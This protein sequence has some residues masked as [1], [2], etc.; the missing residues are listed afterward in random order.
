M[1]CEA[2]IKAEIARLEYEE[3]SYPNYGK[4]AILYT[5]LNQMNGQPSYEAGYSS[6]PAPALVGSA[7]D[8]DS[9][10]LRVAST[11]DPASTWAIMD[12]LMDTLSVTNPRVYDNVMRRINAL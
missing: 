1:L 10:F 11:K 8:S 9:E 2:E 6:A 12:D 5:I 4:L 7:I 3:S